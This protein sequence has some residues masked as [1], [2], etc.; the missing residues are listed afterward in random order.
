[1]P[2]PFSSRNRL[3]EKAQISNVFNNSKKIKT[4]FYSLLFCENNLSFPRL[5]IVIKKAFV[6]KSVQRNKIKRI[7]KE[8]FRLNQHQIPSNDIIFYAYTNINKLTSKELRQWLEKSWH[9]IK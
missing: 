4:P 6:A 7:V 3:K 2:F 5:A 8:S 1:M 9:Q